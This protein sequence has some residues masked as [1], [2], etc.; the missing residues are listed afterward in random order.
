MEG[1][2]KN[3]MGA[4]PAATDEQPTGQAEEQAGGEQATPEE[5]ENL[6]RIVYAAMEI[7]HAEETNP[8][9][10]DMLS[11]GANNPAQ[12]MAD[13]FSIIMQEIVGQIQGQ[14]DIGVIM[15]SSLEVIGMIG[16]L[17]EQAGLFKVDDQIN[18][19]AMQLVV[20][21][22]AEQ[23]GLDPEDIEALIAEFGDQVPG[24]V[25]QMSAVAGGGAQAAAPA[26][27]QQ[28]PAGAQQQMMGGG[29]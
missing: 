6:E 5:Q 17:A 7:L 15:E 3:A 16:T 14:V 10:M 27:A 24:M 20:V 2:L 9:I 29:V 11:S 1:M 26:P 21:M 12:A 13:V 22:I 28:A 18:A 4:A 8:A 23:L 25:D 19:Q